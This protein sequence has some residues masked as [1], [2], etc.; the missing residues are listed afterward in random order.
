[1][2]PANTTQACSGCGSI[3]PKGLSVRVHSCHEC[4]LVLNRDVNAAR[5]I[6]SLALQNP[7]G[8]SGQALTCPIGE[9]VA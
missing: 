1:V 3:I 4:G 9:S 2:S 6:L 8:R 7:L 5:N